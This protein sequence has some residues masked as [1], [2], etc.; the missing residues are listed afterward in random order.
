MEIIIKFFSKIVCYSLVVT[1]IVVRKVRV[2]KLKWWEH[3]HKKIL[4]EM[5]YAEQ[6]KALLSFKG[7]LDL[8][9]GNTI[10]V[11]KEELPFAITSPI[12][13]AAKINEMYVAGGLGQGPVSTSYWNQ[14]VSAR[15]ESYQQ[16]EL[17]L[18]RM[19]CSQQSLA[20]NPYGSSAYSD[21][22]GVGG[23]L[24]LGDYGK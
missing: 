3:R 19:L 6:R 20:Y 9:P 22:L 10:E 7:F 17:A 18:Q 21:Y 24:I 13:S 8:K 1:W 2:I 16:Q 15:Q 4:D 5:F 11:I 12:S 23:S 14:M